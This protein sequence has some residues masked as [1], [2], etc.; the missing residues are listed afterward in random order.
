MNLLLKSFTLLLFLV[1]LV[2]AGKTEKRNGTTPCKCFLPISGWTLSGE[3]KEIC[4][5][6][7][8]AH[9]NG[10]TQDCVI[11]NS[12]WLG[13][14][15]LN[16]MC[17][18]KG[19]S[20]C[21]MKNRQLQKRGEEETTAKLSS[22]EVKS[23]EKDVERRNNV[24]STNDKADCQCLNTILRSP[25]M[26]KSKKACSWIGEAVWD[27]SHKSCRIDEANSLMI[28]EFRR[29]CFLSFSGSSC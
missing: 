22:E 11:S 26:E 19:F 25:V 3:T 13:P 14:G 4:E 24:P 28:E 12:N 10:D 7:A 23:G 15:A 16:I 9:F 6:L 5:T 20:N 2:A 17:E 27:D 1:G 18:K 21:Q 29:Y 8:G